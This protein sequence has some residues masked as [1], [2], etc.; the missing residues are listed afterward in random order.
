MEFPDLRFEQYETVMKG[1]GDGLPPG[2]I[3]HAASRLP[4]GM[5]IVSVWESQS[6]HDGFAPTFV[7][8]ISDAGAGRPSQRILETQH[9]LKS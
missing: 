4:E 7:K 9:V 1:L 8:A 6:T 2:L 3:V 5:V